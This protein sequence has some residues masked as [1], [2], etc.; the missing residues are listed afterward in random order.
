MGQRLI[1]NY[2]AEEMEKLEREWMVNWPDMGPLSSPG[3]LKAQDTEDRIAYLEKENARLRE[4][5]R[6]EGEISYDVKN[7]AEAVKLLTDAFDIGTLI[8]E[9]DLAFS[10]LPERTIF[11]LLTKIE[12]LV[13]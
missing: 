4:D 11:A 9:A 2:T 6:R 13:K 7:Y 8:L 10:T 3:T 12:A 1:S 5:I